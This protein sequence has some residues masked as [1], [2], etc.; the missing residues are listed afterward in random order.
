[1][2]GSLLYLCT[3]VCMRTTELKGSHALRTKHYSLKGNLWDATGNLLNLIFYFICVPRVYL[4]PDTW[5][6]VPGTINHD[7]SGP[8]ARKDRRIFTTITFWSL[9]K[10][11]K[12]IYYQVWYWCHLLSGTHYTWYQVSVIMG[13]SK[14]FTGINSVLGGFRN[15]QFSFLQ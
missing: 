8:A 2:V 3:G 12:S 9:Y 1:M 15:F 4:A 5:Y 10:C 14:V 13:T 6:H 11:S 7:H